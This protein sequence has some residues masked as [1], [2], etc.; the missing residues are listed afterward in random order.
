MSALK[1]ASSLLQEFFPE[2]LAAE[3]PPESRGRLFFFSAILFYIS[4]MILLQRQWLLGGEM[5]AEM[6]TNYFL[7]AHASSLLQSLFATDAGY[8]PF[9][10]R[11]IALLGS[12]L[13]A[14]ASAYFY[15]W[16]CLL[17]TAALAG[18]FCLAA[19]RPVVQSDGLRFLVALV[20]LV[21]ADFETRSFINFTYFVTFFAAILTALAFTTRSRDFPAW[22]WILPILMLSKP[23]TLSILPAMALVSLVSTPRFR[24]IFLVTLVVCIIQLIQITISQKQGTMPLQAADITLAAKLQATFQYFSSLLSNFILGP[25]ISSKILK[26]FPLLAC[27]LGLILLGGLLTLMLRR[28]H[29]ANILIPIGLSLLFSNV[30]L[31]CFAMSKNWNTDMAILQAAP[32]SRHV[33]AGFFGILLIVA[34]IAVHAGHFKPQKKHFAVCLFLAWFLIS[35]WLYYGLKISRLPTSPVLYNS[36]WQTMSAAIDA[37]SSTLCVPLDPFGWVFGKNCRSLDPAMDWGHAFTYPQASAG[38][39]EIDIPLPATVSGQTLF[40]LSALVRPANK[41]RER[42]QLQAVITEKNGRV[43]VLNGEQSLPASGGLITLHI[44]QAAGLSGISQLQLRS[45]K[46]FKLAYTMDAPVKPAIIWMG[47]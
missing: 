36:Q 41:S 23:A 6:A 13:T 8:I 31:N 20:V 26:H 42:I 12:G 1:K 11:L 39:M 19:F 21:V 18:S 32:L 15:T 24:N 34:C 35:G 45:D 22:A 47:R 7:N 5:W 28:R 46:A 37:D 33:S 38:K 14:G 4:Y 3:Q 10:Q 40:A 29:A 17:A 30:L 27:L 44:P 25:G 2:T 16:A 43:T 9:P